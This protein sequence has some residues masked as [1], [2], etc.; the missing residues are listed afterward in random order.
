MKKNLF[1]QI[2]AE[3]KAERAASKDICEAKKAETRRKAETLSYNLLT[4]VYAPSY[5]AG[6]AYESGKAVVEKVAATKAGQAV[7][8]VTADVKFS[9]REGFNNGR[10]AKIEADSA[11]M[12]RRVMN[13]VDSDLDDEEDWEYLDGDDYEG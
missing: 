8:K 7:K 5:V 1:A 10:E 11:R 12:Y 9:A 2:A 3:I 6:Y 4:G 13:Q